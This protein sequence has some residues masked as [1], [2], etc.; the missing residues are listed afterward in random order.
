MVI[1]TPKQFFIVSGGSDGF[2]PL[3][4][5]DGALLSAG[6]QDVNLIRLSSILPP[7]CEQ[8]KPIT[9]PPGSLIPVA[10][11]T[12]SSSLYGE[13]L[14]SAVAIGIPIDET[15]AGLIMEYSEKGNYSHLAEHHVRDMVKAGMNMRNR[16]IKE[17][18]SI[19]ASHKVIENGSCFAGVVLW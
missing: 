17:I 5:F 18:I 9:L 12:I 11:A 2:S 19:S 16:E 7:Y 8:I 6:I 1:Q 13:H 15:Q 10:Y 4:S 3:N 14:C